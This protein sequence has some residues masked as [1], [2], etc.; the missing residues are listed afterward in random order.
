M[1]ALTLGSEGTTRRAISFDV[2]VPV[3]YR[4]DGSEERV[5]V[6]LALI[7]KGTLR[8]VSTEDPA[9]HPLP[10]FGAW[11][12]TRL[13]VEMLEALVPDFSQDSTSSRIQQDVLQDIVFA[14]APETGED[15]EEKRRA[16]SENFIKWLQALQQAPENSGRTAYL[17]TFG[18]LALSFLDHF[19]L[20]V[21]VKED[22]VGTRCVLK[23]AYDSDLPILDEGN[24]VAAT[25]M[26]IP[27][28]GFARSQHIEVTVP[29]GLCARELRVVDLVDDGALDTKVDTP[30]G[31]RSTAH[32]ALAA[33]E[34]TSVGEVLIEMIPA[35]PGIHSFTRLGLAVVSGLVAVGLAEKWDWVAVV[36]QEFKVP[37]QSASVLLIGPALFLSWMA[38]SPEHDAVALLLKPLRLVLMYC[39]IVLLVLATAAAV[40]LTPEAWEIAWEAAFGGTLLAVVSYFA[41]LW[42]APRAIA[43]GATLVIAGFK[44]AS[45]C[46]K[47][48]AN[49]IKRFLKRKKQKG[50]RLAKRRLRRQL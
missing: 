28:I 32:V 46:L 47:N 29:T 18:R 42:N 3:E 30:E 48:G 38:R 15:N 35:G 37:S 20:V 11:K 43:R 4:I 50:R 8:K 49:Q 17:E 13:A 21:E 7:E 6:P 12:N 19:L 2:E 39:T 14:P 36:T 31:E 5:L 23:F 1:D 16:A 40:P 10:V 24:Y 34:R 22:F 9:G 45:S 41:Y 33:A 25:R 26:I 44:A 27:D